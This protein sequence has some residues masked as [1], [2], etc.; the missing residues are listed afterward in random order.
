MTGRWTL[1]MPVTV[2]Y[3]P[4]GLARYESVYGT[5]VRWWQTVQVARTSQRQCG[6]RRIGVDKG[7]TEVLTDSDGV[8]YGTELGRLLTAHSDRPSSANARRA[9]LRAVADR[10]DARGDR[11]KAQR[12][13][14]NNLGVV[15]RGR[16]A[17]RW[18]ARVRTVTFEAVH[19]VVDK[20]ELVVTEDLT[21]SFVGRKR[22]GKNTNRR[23]AGW[24]KGLT[25]RNIRTL[26]SEQSIGSRQ[27]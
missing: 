12:I 10:A 26:S 1:M 15:K 21:K 11:A 2:A 8:R 16:Q 4:I 14:A 13:R 20:A 5:R 7:Y 19:Q 23:L 25:E 9:K 3:R 27:E 6:E 17:A 18:Q 22:L 24:T